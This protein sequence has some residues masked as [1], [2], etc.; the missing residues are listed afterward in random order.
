MARFDALSEQLEKALKA[1]DSLLDANHTAAIRLFNG[2][3][4]GCPELVADLFARTLVLYGYAASVEENNLLLKL[5]QEVWLTRLPW[6]ECVIHKTRSAPDPGTRRGQVTYG[7]APDQQIR[8]HGVWYAVDL[9][10]NQD[11]SLY[12][13]TRSLRAWLLANASG[14][15]VLN[16][17]AYTG[18]LGIAVMAGGADRVVQVD[19]SRKFLDLARRSCTLNNL[20]AGGKMELLTVDFF[21]AAAH[22]KR[23][24]ELFDCVIVDPPYFSTTDKGT[25]NLEMEAV[26]V[27]N[28][29]RPLVKDGGVIV[30]INNALFL[31][32]SDYI[33]SLEQLSQDGYLSIETLLPVPPDFTGYPETVMAYPPVDPAPFNHPTKI[34]VLKVSR[35][36]TPQQ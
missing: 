12:L 30:A 35:K 21:S 23:R 6:L 17:F 15:S 10:M 28:K 13:D 3:Y 36:S 19:R 2:F 32:G 24:A 5:A 1:R 22:F 34:A 20:D 29:V 11:S 14:W 4:E 9:L 31:K 25:V 27:I 8:E 7:R 18:A 33:A 16:M 26:R